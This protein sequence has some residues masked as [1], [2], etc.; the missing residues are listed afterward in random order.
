MTSCLI[1]S[2]GPVPTDEYRVVEGGGLRC[3]GLAQG[4]RA[5]GVD[6]TVAV[7]HGYPQRQVEHDGIALTNWTLD[8]GLAPLVNSYD[9]VLVSFCMGDLSEAIVDVVNTD[10]RLVLDAYVPIYVEVSARES[11]DR[12]AEYREYITELGRWNKV[13]LRGDYFL[14]ASETQKIFYTGVLSVL[15]RINPLTYGDDVIHVVPYG[16]PDEPPR[17]TARA[18]RGSQLADDD[19]VVLWFGGLYPWFD[20]RQLIR[21]VENLAAENPKVKLL[22]V[23]G[24]NPFNSRPD[25]VRQYDEVVAF[26]KGR[27]LVEKS[28]FFVDWV[29][30]DTR[31]DWYTTAD[32]IISINAAGSEN[33]FAWRTR[34][35][36]YVWAETPIATNGG[37]PLSEH[38]IAEGAAYRLGST[39]A[40]GLKQALESLSRSDGVE[41]D[42]MRRRMHEV[43]P[44][45]SWSRITADLANYIERGRRP[46]DSE[47]PFLQ[48]SMRQTGPA[49]GAR[50]SGTGVGALVRK[51]RLL[52]LFARQHGT[53]A[54]LQQTAAVAKSLIRRRGGAPEYVFIA[55]QLDNSGAP[56]VLMDMVREFASLVPPGRTRLITFP[57]IDKDN[58]RTVRS[59]GVRVEVLMHSWSQLGIQPADFVLMNTL[60]VPPVYQDQVLRMLEIGRLHEAH[61][62]IHEDEPEMNFD[63]ALEKRIRDLLRQGK[64]KLLVPGAKAAANYRR[65]FD[66]EPGVSLFNYRFSLD[67]RYRRHVTDDDFDAIKFH[68]TGTAND[69]R[70]G[71]MLV[72]SAFQELLCRYDVDGPGYRPF[73]VHMIGLGTDFLSRQI[74]ALGGQVLGHRFRHLPKLS[75]TEALAAIAACNVGICYSLREC[76]PANIQESLFMGHVVLRN[77]CSGIDEQLEVGRNG[78]LLDSDDIGQFAD[79]LEAV[80]NRETTTNARLAAMGRRSQE[81]VAP[82]ER[83]TYYD[84]L[85]PR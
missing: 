14:C 72:L 23:G 37:D 77:D 2:H 73:E 25:F 43:K 42:G 60:A 64:L 30:F 32:V 68:L 19:F 12:E 8:A 83:L 3:W 44:A 50:P 16:I 84:R 47:Q 81:M 85:V 78:W 59:W 52:P 74:V 24:K 13:L 17:A 65:Y 27:G 75:R 9:T 48:E 11:D 6:V 4:L 40:A 31:A 18:L 34:V 61:W 36:D 35:M 33:A 46:A 79:T 82:F 55:H 39:D 15:G 45:F 41:L 5:H 1:L 49:A 28:V 7:H 70:K 62:Y 29:D 26:A 71:H 57:P 10:V 22:V 51:A 54:A 76:L 56:I 67:E 63:S 38:L 80:L 20:I 58:V 21:A 69:G 53:K 66:D